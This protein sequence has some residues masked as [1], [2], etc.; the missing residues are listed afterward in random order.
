MQRILAIFTR[1]YFGKCLCNYTGGVQPS[2]YHIPNSLHTRVQKVL[3]R[4]Y[5]GVCAADWSPHAARRQPHFYLVT[6]RD[7]PCPS[8]MEGSGGASMLQVVLS[9]QS[10]FLASWAFRCAGVRELT[11]CPRTPVTSQAEAVNFATRRRLE[12]GALSQSS[13]ATLRLSLA[14]C[15]WLNCC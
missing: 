9:F 14:P 13:R 4:D 8:E 3:S 15:P 2:Q 1:P 12:S 6:Q 10:G 5:F 7:L 11:R